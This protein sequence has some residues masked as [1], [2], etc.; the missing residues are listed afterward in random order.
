MSTLLSRTE[1]WV[2]ALAG[3]AFLALYWALR[4][5][6]IGQAA[7]DEGDEAP[8]AAYRDRVIAAVTAGLL[9]VIAGAVVALTRSVAWSIPA[10]AAGFGIVL[11]LI[12]FN[13]RYRHASPALRRTLEFSNTA[14][15]ATLLAGILIVINVLAFRYGGRAL[16][17][18]RERVFSLAP[19]T[20]SQLTTLDRPVLLTLFTGNSPS[21]RIASER[22]SQLLDLYRAANP[23]LVRVAAID[24]YRE[25]EKYEAI[26][27]RVPDVAVTQAGGVL[28]EYG[29]GA[30]TSHVVVRNNDLF[31]VTPGG[32]FQGNAA[33]FESRFHGED[34]LT[35]ALIGI[36]EEKKPKLFFTTGHGEPSLGEVDPGRPGSH[37][38]WKARLTAM[39]YEVVEVNLLAD[40]IPEEKSSLLVIPAPKT[41]IKPDE[42][43]KI[44]AY[45]DRGHPALILLGAQ[46]KT[47]LE[48]MLRT[49]NVEIGRGQIIDRRWSLRGRPGVNYV[50]IRSPLGHPIVDALDGR[51]VLMPGSTPLKV[52]G[53]GGGAPVNTNVTA[54]PLLRTSD[55]S[56]AETDLSKPAQFDQ[57]TDEK[58]PLTVGVAVSDR[59]RPGSSGEGA[60]RLVVF[61]SGAMADN[62]V[63]ELEP[64]NQDV[65]MNSVSWLRGRSDVKGIAPKTHV[66]L[67]LTADPILRF[68]LIMVPTVMAVILILGLG[69]ATY[70]AR[71]E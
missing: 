38:V 28:I 57:G 3:A 46:E 15:T 41:P 48:E 65:L 26:V 51:F 44:R 62:P 24:P 2:L 27:K 43:T 70:L 30:K 31:D 59:P 6:P 5:A 21:A 63:L 49:F 29:Q 12:A 66:S 61:S 52:L 13:Q 19:Q 17:F 42:L 45:V 37:G 69:L 1:V 14:L 54:T 36:R 56:W 71:H 35:A 7:E 40:E 60:P 39:G 32:G 18:T 50:P 16:D 23:R 67:T 33:Q 11:T 25:P 4:G 22:M 68:R 8:R 47:G 9:L 10:F 34:A 55:Q 20:L 53:S 64:T 58:G